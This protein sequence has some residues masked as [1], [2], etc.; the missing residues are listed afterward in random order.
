[1]ALHLER[2][3][4]DF[5]IRRWNNH[6]AR[7]LIIFDYIKKMKGWNWK[8]YIIMIMRIQLLINVQRLS[9]SLK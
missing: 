1:M 3:G 4:Y 5:E 7:I 9:N 6:V 8:E 2:N